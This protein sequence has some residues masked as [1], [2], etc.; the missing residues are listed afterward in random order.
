MLHKVHLLEQYE[1]LLS[2]LYVRYIF[3]LLEQP[4]IC[5]FCA[6]LLQVLFFSQL[7][8]TTRLLERHKKY[9]DVKGM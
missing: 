9:A 2:F 8:N 1:I 3:L 6:V 5:V 4:P 7:A